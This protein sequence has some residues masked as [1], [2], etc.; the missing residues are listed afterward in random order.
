MLPG[1]FNQW[2][3]EQAIMPPQPS[4]PGHSSCM[5]LF[6]GKAGLKPLFRGH[7][8]PYKRQLMSPVIIS[9]KQHFV[10]KCVFKLCHH[11]S[12]ASKVALSLSFAE[13]RIVMRNIYTKNL[14]HKRQISWLASGLVSGSFCLWWEVSSFLSFVWLS[15]VF[16]FTLY[17]K[18][19]EE[20]QKEALNE[21]SW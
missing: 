12:S 5:P 8:Y 18:L 20:P 2:N 13:S 1:P 11:F 6:S 21:Y 3:P 14:Q 9:I 16:S 15:P 4:F 7:Y 17:L 10:N 19:L